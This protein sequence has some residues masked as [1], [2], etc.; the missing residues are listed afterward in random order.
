M[1]NECSQILAEFSLPKCAKTDRFGVGLIHTTYLVHAGK[2]K[3][4]L[5]K[6]NPIFGTDI[7]ADTRAVSEFLSGQG[8]RVQK[9][10]PAKNGKLFAEKNGEIWR[11]FTFVPG[12][13]FES[14]T[15]KNMAYEAGKILGRFHRDLLPFKHKFAK[16]RGGKT[17]A[18]RYEKFLKVTAGKQTAEIEALKSEIAHLPEFFLPKRTRLTIMHGDPKLSNIVWNERGAKKAIA[19]IDID[20]CTNKGNTL[21]ELGDAFRS[22]CGG[23]EHDAKN[24]FD[25]GKF[26]AAKAGYAEG[27]DCLLRPNEI[28]LLARATKL[29]CLELASRFLVDYFEDY[30]FGWDEKR[31]SSRREHNLA[32]AK[33][34]VTLCKSVKL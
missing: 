15:D 27:S 28:A 33:G 16:G 25:F 31:F 11:M 5:Q 17:P 18:S 6:M 2:E 12:R 30:Y 14:A 34:Q 1:K 32:R 24:T 29:K 10:L 26:E 3:F 21:L 20:D 19:L 23:R 22:W 4:I 7:L 9:L 13:I 8:W